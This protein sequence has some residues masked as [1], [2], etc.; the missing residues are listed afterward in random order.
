MKRLVIALALAL[1]CSACANSP[2]VPGRSEADIPVRVDVVKL[3]DPAMMKVMTSVMADDPDKNIDKTPSENDQEVLAL[4]KSA[5]TSQFENFG[6]HV[7]DGG[8][9]K[10]DLMVRAY[11][12]YVPESWLIGR[13]VGVAI[14]VDDAAAKPILRVTAMRANTVGL[15]GVLLMSRDGMVT[16]ASREA[17]KKAVDEI[18]KGTK[19]VEAPPSVSGPAPSS[20]TPTS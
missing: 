9:R 16:D 12:S 4:V 14:H 15:V 19:P 3:N 5:V 11:V 2:Y 18:R 6:M 1:T 17:V 10:S 13:S 7:V 20:G 8:D